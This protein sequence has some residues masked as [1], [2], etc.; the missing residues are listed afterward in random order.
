MF[1]MFKS[2]AYSE[3]M[4][5]LEMELKSARILGKNKCVLCGFCCIRRTCIPH[6]NDIKKIADFLKISVKEMINKYFVIDTDE[7][8][9]YLRPAGKNNKIYTGKF[10]PADATYD[11]GKC[12]FLIKDKIRNKCMP[13]LWSHK[14]RIHKV[15]PKSALEC[16]C[17]NEEKE[18]DDSKEW[19]NHNVLKKRFGINGEVLAAEY[20]EF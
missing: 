10:L 6:P 14:C 19:W 20:D 7:G 9:Y 13:R 1:G 12:L 18:S 11:E 5:S 4:K 16:E 8:I 17:W 15:K 2:I 3:K